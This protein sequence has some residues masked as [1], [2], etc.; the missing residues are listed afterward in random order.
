[1]E[2]QCLWFVSIG[3]VFAFSAN[4]GKSIQSSFSSE[5]LLNHPHSQY[6]TT[7]ARDGDQNITRCTHSAGYIS[8][9]NCYQVPKP[10]DQKQCRDAL[11][12]PCHPCSPTHITLPSQTTS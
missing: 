2:M 4:A 3:S 12:S 10:S 7:Q 9:R 6:I 11:S 8:I 1:M 5:A